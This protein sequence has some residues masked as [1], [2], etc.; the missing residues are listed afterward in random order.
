MDAYIEDEWLRDVVLMMI[1][2]I[3]ALVLSGVALLVAGGLVG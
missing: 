1:A 3:V 2:W